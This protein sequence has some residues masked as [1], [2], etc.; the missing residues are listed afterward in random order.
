[1]STRSD[2]HHVD[3][4]TDL[5]TLKST[6]STCTQLCHVPEHSDG[7]NYKTYLEDITGEGH[8]RSSDP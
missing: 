6:V 5:I 1:M 3:G 8:E 7:F 2:T 4:D